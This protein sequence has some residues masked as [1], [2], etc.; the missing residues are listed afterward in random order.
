[1]RPP[2]AAAVSGCLASSLSADSGCSLPP[3]GAGAAEAHLAAAEQKLKQRQAN[4]LPRVESVQ[5]LEVRRCLRL[6]PFVHWLSLLRPWL[7]QCLFVRSFRKSCGAAPSG[8][9]CLVTQ[10][11][12][13]PAPTLLLEAPKQSQPVQTHPV[14]NRCQS[15]PGLTVLV[16]Q[17]PAAGA[18]QA[19]AR[20]RARRAGAHRGGGG[21]RRRLSGRADGRVS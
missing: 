6:V 3:F 16:G 11:P 12:R 18:G 20:G 14:A 21:G 19:R 8:W 4:L 17:D 1:M 15:W 9:R 5:Q 13:A 2:P 10:L 7:R